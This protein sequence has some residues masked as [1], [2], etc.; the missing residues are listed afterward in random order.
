MSEPELSSRPKSSE[1]VWKQRRASAPASYFE[2]ASSAKERRSGVHDPSCSIPMQEHPSSLSKSLRRR[3]TSETDDTESRNQPTHVSRS[4]TQVSEN[5][6]GRNMVKQRSEAE[7]H[8]PAYQLVSALSLPTFLKTRPVLYWPQSSAEKTE[9]RPVERGVTVKNPDTLFKE[10]WLKRGDTP[11]SEVFSARFE[12]ED[13]KDEHLAVKLVLCDEETVEMTTEEEALAERSEFENLT[14]VNH[15]HI[16]SVVGS[17]EEEEEFGDRR[18]G[19][20]LYPLAMTNLGEQLSQLSQHNESREEDQRWY[21]DEMAGILLSYLPCLC[22]TLIYLHET[23]MRHQDVKPSNIFIDAYGFVLLADFDIAKKHSSQQGD[24]TNSQAVNFTRRYAPRHVT[25]LKPRGRE[26]DIFSLGCVFLE[27]ASVIMGETLLRL[28]QHL[29]CGKDEP[30]DDWQCIDLHYNEALEKGHID[31]WIEHLKQ[32][33]KTL[34]DQQAP[35]TRFTSP[36]AQR[37]DKGPNA[38]LDEFYEQI[39]A[40]LHATLG[41]EGI[42]ESAWDY[43][44]RLSDHDCQYCHPKV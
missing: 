1:P 43:F 2:K 5:S 23:A 29:I 7:Y 35:V 20:L 8:E 37:S 31:S 33:Y 41:S 32:T 28:Q 24:I 14:S 16:I 12:T 25:D 42:L 30:P 11:K 44:N 40:M 38:C 6:T 18:F 4:S 13:G 15:N 22:R 21:S 26:W 34:P 9:R 17:F 19:I 10:H 27:I 39:K 36:R 3:L